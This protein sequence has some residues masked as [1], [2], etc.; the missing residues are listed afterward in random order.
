MS[1]RTPYVLTARPP[2]FA[3]G[4]AAHEWIHLSPRAGCRKRYSMESRSILPSC[5]CSRS[6]H[7]ALAILGMHVLHPELHGRRPS[8]WSGGKAEEL[9]EPVVDEGAVS[10]STS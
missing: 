5:N 3:R 4:D 8:S 7:D 2:A 6:V 1:R 9:A 10:K